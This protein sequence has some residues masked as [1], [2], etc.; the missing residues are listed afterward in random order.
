MIVNQENNETGVV[1]GDVS[2]KWKEI[3]GSVTGFEI[4]NFGNVRVKIKDNSYRELT[5]I[6]QKTSKGTYL[7]AR[8]YYPEIGLKITAIHQLVIK[9]FKGLPPD[10]GLKYEPNHMDGNK[11]NN[12][13]DNLEWMTR[14]Q[15][16]LHA[17][18]TGLCKVGTRVKVKDITT[19]KEINFNTFSAMA[20][21]FG[22]SRDNMRTI[23]LKHKDIPY[24]S[25]WIFDVSRDSDLN[26]DRYQRLE[27][28]CKDYVTNKLIIAIDAIQMSEFTNTLV[29]TITSRVNQ[30]SKT[31]N[32]L[33]LING[34]VFKSL[35][36]ETPWPKYSIEE[37]LISR[38]K[39]LENLK[40]NKKHENWLRKNY[41][42][43][44][45]TEHK[46][47]SKACENIELSI[48]R[49]CDLAVYHKQGK[50]PCI[51]GYAFKKIS[52]I[53]PWPT[54]SKEEIDFS[55]DNKPPG[56]RGKKIRVTDTILNTTKNYAAATIFAREI[57]LNPLTITVKINN[58]KNK[59]FLDKYKIEFLS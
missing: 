45:I 20:R 10:N 27:I 21:Y 34:Y 11:H 7:Y 58:S 42:T 57:G 8:I 56:K 40:E 36:D 4:S 9:A 51:K 47:L 38:N 28:I 52:N 6:E 32:K 25:K 24:L 14:S 30:N 43:G 53:L 37:A 55:F 46:S 35:L 31:K 13:A 3:E 26:I 39:Y 33:A 23:I 15:N 17:F 16:V 19:S 49:I 50:I 22:L 2:E 54:F 29:G 41:I 59:L 44:D 5:K 12:R 48:G 1:S 18:E